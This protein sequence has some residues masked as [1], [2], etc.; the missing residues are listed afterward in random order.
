MKYWYRSIALILA[1]WGIAAMCAIYMPRDVARQLDLLNPIPLAWKSISG[2][3]GFV[4][5]DFPEI[6]SIY[7][8][9][10][11]FSYPMF[12]YIIWH[13]LGMCLKKGVDGLLV[14]H[15]LSIG[16]K[17]FIIFTVPVFLLLIYG[18]AVGNEGQGLRYFELGRS[19]L[20][21]AIFGILAPAAAAI[22]SA[23]IAFGIFRVFNFRRK[24]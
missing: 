18:V 23:I 21:L 2:W 14:K 11:W 15:N 7:Y 19:R 12:F 3:R 10:A 1:I 24:T 17:I 20:D 8:S 16:D 5:S 6:S 4:R 9:I 13:W 22:C